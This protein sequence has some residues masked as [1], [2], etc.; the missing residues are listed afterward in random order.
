[1]AYAIYLNKSL[2]D[3]VDV[4]FAELLENCVSESHEKN[5]IPSLLPLPG[6]STS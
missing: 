4:D 5:L 3:H 2:E 1:M 6:P